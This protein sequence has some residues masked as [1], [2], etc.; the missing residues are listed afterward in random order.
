MALISVPSTPLIRIPSGSTISSGPLSGAKLPGSILTKA[1]PSSSLCL[2]IQRDKTFGC[3]P[4]RLPYSVFVS[5]LACQSLTRSGLY[6]FLRGPLPGCFFNA[7]RYLHENI[8]DD[9]M[10]SGFCPDGV[11]LT[12]TVNTVEE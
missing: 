1:H 2:A 8:H 6:A 7:M 12:L 10:A 5:P 9:S 3:I 4:F 11:W